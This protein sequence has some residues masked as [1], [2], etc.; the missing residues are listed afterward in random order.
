MHITISFSL[1]VVVV[2]VVGLKA[3]SI[4]NLEKE[5]KLTD[6]QNIFIPRMSCV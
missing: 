2:D 6:A 4:S 3:E 1:R 5:T